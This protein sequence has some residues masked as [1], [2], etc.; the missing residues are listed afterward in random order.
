MP[1]TLRSWI[2]TLTPPNCEFWRHSNDRP[3]RKIEYAAE[4]E[5][6]GKGGITLAGVRHATARFL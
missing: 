6:I 3:W 2:L 4:R 1:E 5:T